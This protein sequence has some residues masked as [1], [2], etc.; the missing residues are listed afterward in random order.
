MLLSQIDPGFAA[1]RTME[2][3]VNLHP[4]RGQAHHRAGGDRPLLTARTVVYHLQ[5]HGDLGSVDEPGQ[6][7]GGVLPM[8]WG[9]VPPATRIHR[10]CGKS[11]TSSTASTRWQR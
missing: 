4:G 8:R 10:W 5:D 7:F 2:L 6:F 9:A 1:K 11:A 3:G